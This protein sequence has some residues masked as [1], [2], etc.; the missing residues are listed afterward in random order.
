[1]FFEGL[2]QGVASGQSECV[3]VERVKAGSREHVEAIGNDEL[4]D[5]S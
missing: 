5:V 3:H 2:S 4:V 1:M